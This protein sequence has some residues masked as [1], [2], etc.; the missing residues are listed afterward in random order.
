MVLHLI[1]IVQIL[2]RLIFEIDK[3]FEGTLMDNPYIILGINQNATKKEIKKAIM[4]LLME[5]RKTKKYSGEFIV[6]C[7]RILLDPTKRLAADYLFPTKL[8]SYRPKKIEKLKVEEKNFKIN[9]NI[10][11]SLKTMMLAI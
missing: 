1:S 7:E 4:N 5:N 3:S 10:F 11:S 2:T 6:N 9:E 8:K